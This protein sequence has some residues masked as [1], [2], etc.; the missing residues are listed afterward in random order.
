MRMRLLAFAAIFVSVPVFAAHD[1]QIRARLD[2]TVHAMTAAALAGD[3]DAY[4]SLISKT[5]ASFLNEQKYFANDLRKHQPADFTFEFGEEEP[6]LLGE[7]EARL[8]ITFTWSLPGKTEP[9][10]PRK[11]SFTARFVRAPDGANTEW[12]YAGEAWEAFEA[13]GVKVMYLPESNLSE[14]AKNAADAFEAIRAHVEKLFE[15]TDK[16]LPHRTQQI[17]LYKGMAHLHFSIMLSYVN[18]IGGWNEPGESIKLRAGEQ[19]KLGSLRSLLAHEYGHVASFELGPKASVMPW[20]IIE[21]VAEF[22]ASEYGKGGDFRARQMWRWAAEDKLAPWAEISD[23]EKTP[24]KYMGHVYAQGHQMVVFLS[25]KFG[26]TKRNQ[27][28]TLLANSKPLEEATKEAFGVTFEELDTEWRA[29]LKAQAE[30]AAK[31]AAKAEKEAEKA[32]SEGGKK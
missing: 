32:A 21:G 29:K 18:P 2:S 5:D 25:E 16:D 23:F 13:P 1:P 24:G 22:S 31:E 8:P 19:T 11:V 15:L 7:T 17:K 26:T 14:T 10:K 30:L 28:L 12:L 9:G 27:W 4:L 6:T 3:A 20:W